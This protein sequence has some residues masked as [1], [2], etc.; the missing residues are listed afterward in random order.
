MTR[1]QGL[2]GASTVALKACAA[3]AEPASRGSSK[4]TVSAV[5]DTVAPANPGAVVS[6]LWRASCASPAWPSAAS[7]CVVADLTVPPFA[8]SVSAS[9]AMP[10]VE[11]SPDTTA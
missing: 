7:V 10:C 4:V 1:C 9:T 8:S 6:T 3:G 2:P 11:V 5:P